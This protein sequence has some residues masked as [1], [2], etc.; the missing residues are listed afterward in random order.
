MSKKYRPYLTLE[1]LETIK[2]S[3][4][5]RARGEDIKLLHYLDTYLLSIQA[6]LKKESYTAQGL[7]LANKILDEPSRYPP[8]A[9]ST[10][11][12]MELFS[13]S[14]F[15]GLSQE[16]ISRVQAYRYEYDLMNPEEE[17]SYENFLMKGN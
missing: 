14:G 7:G 13:D 1:E 17:I 16:E 10:A 5:L 8:S 6:G 2:F 15:A 11:K 9:R 12:L 3:V 4:A